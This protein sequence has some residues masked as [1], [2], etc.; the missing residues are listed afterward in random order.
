MF[1]FFQVLHSIGIAWGLGA[2]TIGFLGMRKGQKDPQFGQA[3]TKFLPTITNLIWIALILLVVS[4]VGLLVLHPATVN[5]SAAMWGIKHVVVYF[6]IV[7]GI[8]ITLVIAP[9]LKRLAPQAGANPSPE[10]LKARTLMQRLGVI[11]LICWYVVVV[12]SV[13]IRI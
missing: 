6:I 11:N 1:Q 3:W 9:K 5:Y 10:F 7:A 13:F 8:I 4:G 12:L 2:A